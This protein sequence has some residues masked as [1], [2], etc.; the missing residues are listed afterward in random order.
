[1]GAGEGFIFFSGYIK[2]HYHSPRLS[3][4]SENKHVKSSSLIRQEP[5]SVQRS[6]TNPIN[7]NLILSE[8]KGAPSLIA[9]N[10]HHQ[11]SM[12]EQNSILVSVELIFI[13][14]F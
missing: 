6:S 1:V 4:N 3:M 5:T 14:P 10:W 12:S 8:G 7:L 2:Q 13:S 11:S 9:N